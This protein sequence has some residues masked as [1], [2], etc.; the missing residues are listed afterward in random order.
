MADNLELGLN[1][2]ELVAVLNEA[3]GLT[4]QSSGGDSHTMMGFWAFGA[5]HFA[6]GGKTRPYLQALIGYTSESATGSDGVGG[7]SY[8]F[9][10][11]AKFQ[12]SGGLLLNAG[13]SYKFYTYTPSG[14]SSRYGQNILAIGLGISGFLGK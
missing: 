11:G 7:L 9:A 4:T 5:Y 8:G 12:I 13:L 14:A 2:L 1:P 10:G 6:T 3:S